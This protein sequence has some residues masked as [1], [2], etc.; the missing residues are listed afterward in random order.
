MYIHDSDYVITFATSITSISN[1]LKKLQI[2]SYF[3]SYYNQTVYID[4][5]EIINNIFRTY[6]KP[7]LDDINNP[8]LEQECK[9]NNNDAEYEKQLDGKVNRP[10]DKNIFIVM[11]ATRTGK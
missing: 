6:V 1:T 9:L 11:I 4:K 10:S 3:H 7:L 5:E 2:Q 8:E